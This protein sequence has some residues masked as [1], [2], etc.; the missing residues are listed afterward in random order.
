MYE[1]VENLNDGLYQ[2]GKFAGTVAF[3]KFNPRLSADSGFVF[4]WDSLAK[5]PYL[6]NPLKKLFVTYDDK[7]SVS[8]KTRYA[9]ENNL[10]G[11]MFWQLTNDSFSDGLLDAIYKAKT[12]GILNDHV[13][14]KS[15][16]PGK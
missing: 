15:Q 7:R 10:G 2:P 9:I 3:N 4:H 1:Q 14:R 5:A 11:I 12:G 16:T 8:L 6:Y 13:L